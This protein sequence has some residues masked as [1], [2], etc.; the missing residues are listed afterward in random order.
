MVEHQE[1]K[2][3]GEDQSVSKDPYKRKF[4]DWPLERMA[5]TLKENLRFKGEPIALAWTT[6]LPFDTEPYAGAL[7]LVHCQFMQRSRLHGET[8][9][10]DFDHVDDICA[11]YSY[12]GLGE[13]PPNL[14][15]GYS[16]SRRKDGKPSIYGSPTAARR[17]KEKY[18]NIEPGTVKYFCCAPLSKSPFDPDV[19]TIIAD[20]KT[21][22]Y[23]VRAAIHYRGGIVEGITGPGTCSASWIHAYLS[24]EIRYTLGCRGVFGLMGVG[25]TE[26]CLSIPTELLPEICRNLEEWAEYDFSMLYP[27]YGE[28]APNEERD[29]MKA[30]Y[31][32]PYRNQPLEK[33]NRC[34]EN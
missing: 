33:R 30:P 3:E 5:K 10:L 28:E 26:I 4:Y 16:W 21:C 11:G 14:A 6:E 17:V 31:E 20:P 27:L 7:K 29:W 23:A 24:G 2:N 9:I 15:S 1:K 19:V 18:R 25:P 34:E 13:P 22:T 8:F 12:I 32:G